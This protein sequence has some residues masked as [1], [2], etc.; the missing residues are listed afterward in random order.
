MPFVLFI[1]AVFQM[2]EWELDF[3]WLKVRHKLKDVLK[4][5]ALPDMKSIL[6]IIGVQELGRVEKAFS[7]EEKRDLMHVAAC[8]LLEK[9]GYYV[10]SGRDHDGWPHWEIGKPF[11]IKGVEEQ[12]KILKINI[13]QYFKNL[14]NINT[15]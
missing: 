14:D 5:D 8:A 9:D 12:E 13:I 1:F 15:L 4:A 3:Q 7:K 11:K 10:F 6:F 2:E